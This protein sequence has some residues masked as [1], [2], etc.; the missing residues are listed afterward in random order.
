MIEPKMRGDVNGDGKVSASDAASILRAAV[1]LELYN[2]KQ[3]EAGDLN[4]D[5]VVG[6]VEASRILRYLVRLEDEL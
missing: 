2:E 6:A 1:R 4:G 5:G 3:I